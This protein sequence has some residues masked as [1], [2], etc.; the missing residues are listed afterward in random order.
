MEQLNR[1]ELEEM[2]G[3]VEGTVGHT[4]GGSVVISIAREQE[5]NDGV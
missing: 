4:T 1:E 5:Y 2:T 3:V